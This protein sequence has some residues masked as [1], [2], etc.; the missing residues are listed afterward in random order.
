MKVNR[1]EKMYKCEIKNKI[2]MTEG[3]YHRYV[4]QRAVVYFNVMYICHRKHRIYYI[5]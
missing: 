2:K 1:L 3:V 4:S 5:L